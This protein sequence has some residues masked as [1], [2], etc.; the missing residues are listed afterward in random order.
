MEISL[1]VI[2]NIFIIP[3]MHYTPIILNMQMI[4]EFFGISREIE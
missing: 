1:K 3:Y 4:I 2:E